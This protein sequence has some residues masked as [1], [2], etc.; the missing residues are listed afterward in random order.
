M[1]NKDKSLP[2]QFPGN[3]SYSSPENDVLEIKIPQAKI[4]NTSYDKGRYRIK[5]IEKENP[6]FK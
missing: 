2:I 6:I 4:N 1:W 3:L 5:L